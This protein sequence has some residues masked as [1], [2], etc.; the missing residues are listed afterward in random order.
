M[1]I[2]PICKSKLTREPSRYLCEKGHS[3]DIS[4]YGHVNLLMSQKGGNHG[5][6]REMLLS[7]KNF[8]DSGAYS[9]LRNALADSVSAVSEGKSTL[10]LLD[11]GCGEC[12]YTSLI[13]DELSAGGTN[14]HII[15][16]DIS[17]EALRIAAQRFNGECKR[18]DSSVELAV[19][20]S[21]QLPIAESSID[22]VI[23]VFAPLCSEEFARVL[24]RG[25]HF[26][27]VIPGK[28]HL[29]ELKA[30]IYDDPY[31]NEIMPYEID[32]FRMISK[33]ELSGRFLLPSSSA[34]ADLFTMTPYFCRT[35]EKDKSKLH[36][37]NSLE[38]SYEFEILVYEKI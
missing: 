6:S 16:I 15:G 38:C 28:K 29:W 5:D 17:K 4:K 30:A 21:Y 12:Y 20:S 37:L 25:G 32:K 34:I 19:A 3:H 8:L 10:S 7:R 11:S 36:A 33:K 9:P 26:I 2:C 22:T 13:K 35:S 18:V 27:T 31:E 24:K 23:S 14:A 1:L